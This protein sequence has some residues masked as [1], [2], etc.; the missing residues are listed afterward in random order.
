MVVVQIS[1]VSQFHN[2]KLRFIPYHSYCKSIHAAHFGSAA[3]AKINPCVFN[4]LSM[5]TIRSRL[6]T[7]RSLHLFA[8]VSHLSGNLFTRF[9]GPACA[10]IWS[11]TLKLYCKAFRQNFEKYTL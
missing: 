11:T 2:A 10:I 6:V 3:D 8:G 5:A 4:S 7:N 9:T 1:S